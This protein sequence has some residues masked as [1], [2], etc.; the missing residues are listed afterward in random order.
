[1]QQS[2]FEAQGQNSQQAGHNI[3]NNYDSLQKRYPSYL[4][5]IVYHLEKNLESPVEQN[6][7]NI[8]PY[9]ITSKIEHNNVIR[10][11]Q[12]I[13][14]Y[15]NYGAIIDNIL[16]SMDNEKPNSK[17][18]F[19]DSIH[20]QYK[21]A[22]GLCKRNHPNLNELDLIRL[23]SDDI[24]DIV[25]DK[26]KVLF[27]TSDCDYDIMDEDINECIRII[28]CKAFIDCKILEPPPKLNIQ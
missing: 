5:K 3:I 14:D 6:I 9:E 13:N 12:T 7:P 10:Y 11:R 2:I 24:I 22:L 28:V 25:F 27:I 8:N 20:R 23:N 4:T 17:K 15:G 18:R 19:L 21:L 1:M 26:L 16:E